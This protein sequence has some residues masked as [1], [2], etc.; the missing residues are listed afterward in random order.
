MGVVKNL[1]VRI[2]ADVRGVVNGMKS[3]RSSTSQAADGI[4]KSTKETKQS[5]I[6][7]FTAPAKAVKEYS[8]EVSRTKAAHQAAVQNTTVLTD[9]I[10]KLEDVYGTVKNATDSLDLS[11]PLKEQISAAEKELDN[12]NAKIHKTQTAI[13]AMGNPRSAAKAARL[14]NLQ[15]ELQNLIVDSDA[16]AAHLTA[17]DQAADRVGANGMGY[18]SAAGMKKLQE[19]I[20]TAK[21]RLEVTKAVAAETENK[22]KSM[23]L[24]PTLLTMLKKVGVAATQAAG[25]GIKHLAKN[26]LNIGNNASAS[27]GGLGKMVRSIRNIGIASLGMRVATGMFGRMRS[28]ISSYIYQNEALNKSVTSL[29]NQMGE[30]LLPAINMVMVAMQRLMPIVQAVSNVINSIFTALFGKMEATGTA[31]ASTA[32][33][34]ASAAENLNTYGFDQITKESDSSAGGG[35][36]NSGGGSSGQEGQQSA[37]VQKLTAWI[38]ALKAAFVA[39]DWENLGKIVGDGI[40]AAVNAINS[41]DIGS[42]IGS[43]V[44]NFVT[45]LHS[46]LTTTDFSAIGATV[47]E[48]ISSAVGQVNWV[49]VGEVLGMGWQ[50]V[51]DFFVGLILNTDWALVGQSLTDCISGFLNSVTEWIST[52]DWLQLGQCAATL[53]ANVDWGQLSSSLFTSVGACLGGLGQFVWGVIGEEWNSMMDTW[54]KYTELCG[55]DAIAGLLTGILVGLA[56]IGGWIWNNIFVPIWNGVRGAFGIHSPS[57]KMAEI[58]GHVA[59]GFLGG[60]LNGLGNIIEWVSTN[61]VKPFTDGFESI[62]TGATDAFEGLWTGIKGWINKIIGGVESMAN[63]VIRGINGLIDSFNGLAE[64]GTYF[65]INLQI[66][67]L[68]SVYL[69]RLAKGTV[70]DKPTAAIIGEAG[71]EAVMPL[72]NNTGWITQLASKINKAGGNAANKATT[73]IL[74]IYFRTRK[75]A[76]Y[77]I[78]DINQMSKENGTCPIYV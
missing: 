78:Q 36:G 7:G 24:G 17:L 46:A 65:G 55:G 8:A 49:K 12:I 4:K 70:V 50:M 53:I 13:N 59:G 40:N 67:R 10:A 75:L 25:S 56:D 45:T 16:A 76:E 35:S 29:K 60:I 14:E 34:A 18:A 11:K 28:I 52:V 21:S 19:E 73:L 47:G 74:P 57:T 48:I 32:E 31:I 41:V 68:D 44:A 6:D 71:K 42:K 20:Q 64:V 77:V 43:F 69:P 3:A 72:E 27:C 66:P 15:I 51:E 33:E 62:K 58:G 9:E 23:R 22:L 5:I 26:I 54:L 30:A 37:L 39:G 63:W 61:V 38:E 2:G 1:M